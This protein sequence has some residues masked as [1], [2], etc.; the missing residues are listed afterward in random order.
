[1]RMKS[2]R[3]PAV[4]ARHDRAYSFLE[5]LIS[6]I[7][8]LAGILAILNFFPISVKAAARAEHLTVATLLAQQKAEELRR[9]ND[10]AGSLIDSIRLRTEPTEPVVFSADDRFTYSFSGRSLLDGTDDADNPAD[11]FFVPRVIVRYNPSFRD[12][13]DVVY[14]LRFD[15]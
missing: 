2:T 10:L 12:S 8:F 14:E 3:L 11:D 4:G 5:I 15:Q 1:M 9:D 6:L 7:I 13:A